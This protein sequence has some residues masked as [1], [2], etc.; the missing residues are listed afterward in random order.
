[1]WI[2]SPQRYF[3]GRERSTIDQYRN[4]VGHITPKLGHVKLANLTPRGVESF[5]DDLL[6]T[7]SRP[8]ARKVLTSLKSLLRVNKYAHVAADVWIG[9]N[10]RHKRNFEAGR[11]L[12]TPAEIRRMIDSARDVRAR[13]LLLTAALTGLRA[14][15]LRGLRWHDVDLKIGELHVRQRADKYGKIGALKSASNS[16]TVPID[17]GA[18]LRALKTWKLACPVGEA[19][20]VFPSATGKTARNEAMQSSLNPAMIAAGVVDKTGKP[21]YRLHAF[22]H[23]F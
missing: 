15:E 17:P 1:R 12:P 20:F 5:R 13:A 8:T 3:A 14:S 19:G 4:H 18:F 23:F 10:S 22:R 16:R 11:D 6:A 7:L 2:N 21:K 9:T